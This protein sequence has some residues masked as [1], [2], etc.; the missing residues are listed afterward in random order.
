MTERNKIPDK[1]YLISLGEETLTT[2]T[3]LQH[4]VRAAGSTIPE[5]NTKILEES[6]EKAIHPWM[7]KFLQPLAPVRFATVLPSSASSRR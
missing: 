2:E 6:Q 5:V 7:C 3:T 1:F 4:H